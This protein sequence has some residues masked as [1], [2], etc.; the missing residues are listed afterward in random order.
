MAR[1]KALTRE[2]AVE[3]AYALACEHGL[4]AVSARSLAAEC[5]VAPGTLYNYF[6]AKMDL[7]V[8]V[9]G[10]F[11]REELG[12]DMHEAMGPGGDYVAFCRAFF[13]DVADALTRFR[14]DW[15]P[16]LA[17][18]GVSM[19]DCPE[20]IRA[21]DH[22]RAGLVRVLEGDPCV[23]RDR[24]VGELAPERIADLTLTTI[25]ELS[26]GLGAAPSGPNSTRSRVEG[27]ADSS[28]A[29]AGGAD[30]GDA[31]VRVADGAHTNAP[32]GSVPASHT[33]GLAAFE[34]FC[35]MLRM[36]L[37]VTEGPVYRDADDETPV[38]RVDNEKKSGS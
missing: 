28:V 37:Y 13:S 5:G 9:V 6:P 18:C 22:M 35:R 14:R 4:A 23:A 24:L 34:T 3:R 36:T 12:D 26:A 19:T 1:R 15:L 21:L 29:A 33:D 16:Q 32:T 11:W 2:Q 17:A 31:S 7:L 30:S 20:A 38:S 8:A 25:M 10:R 27:D